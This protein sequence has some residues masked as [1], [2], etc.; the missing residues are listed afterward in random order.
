MNMKDK[1]TDAETRVVRFVFG[2]IF[3]ILLFFFFGLYGIFV[4]YELV[5]V[6]LLLSTVTG[7]FAANFGDSFWYWCLRK[8]KFWFLESLNTVKSFSPRVVT[9][10]ILT[11]IL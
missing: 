6:L 7:L 4:G 9:I 3:G 2:F 5:Y 10:D 1:K 11:G 8:I